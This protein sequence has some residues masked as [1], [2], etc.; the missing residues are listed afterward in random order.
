M[1]KKQLKRN[2]M[3]VYF[4]NI[5]ACL[6]GMEACGGAH[7]WAR[8]LRQLGHEVRLIAPQ[9]V[10]PYVKGNKHDVADAAAICEAVSRPRMRFVPVKTEDQQVILAVHRVRDGFVKARTAIANQIRGLLSEFGLVLPE[11]SRLFVIA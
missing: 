1:L 6:I 5:P 2:Q 8:Q 10:K 9:F 4:A 3:L 7:Y 11:A